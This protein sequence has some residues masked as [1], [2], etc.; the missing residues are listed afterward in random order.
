[1]DVATR[2]LL[3][4]EQICQ[5]GE[6]DFT[7]LSREFSVSEMTIRRDIEVLE[8]DGLVRRVVGGAISVRGTS[9]EPPFESR[10]SRAAQ[11]KE[12]IARA[13]VGLLQPG[14]TVLLDSGSTVLSVA[15]ALRGRGLGLTVVTP[16]VLAGI[17]LADEPD[18]TVF[19]TGGKIRSGELSLIGQDTIDAFSKFNG[20]TFVMGVAGVDA[21]A[22]VSDYNY[23]EAHVKMAACRA[24]K[25]VIL[26]ADHTKFGQV[27]LVNIA[28][29]VD[30][31]IIVT[32]ASDDDD[33]LRA[34]AHMGI[35][36]VAAS[37]TRQ[38]LA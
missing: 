24:A 9:A 25:R 17:E 27:S 29:L 16:S 15:R 30:I 26:A 23:E 1:M 35:Q 21:V 7:S 20:N 37:Q 22:G 4:A 10:A 31:D 38:P 5:R 6:V 12:H 19:L 36:I 14:E 28:R 3:I 11:E 32:D 34:A 18:T 2:R 8:E 33:T 13:V